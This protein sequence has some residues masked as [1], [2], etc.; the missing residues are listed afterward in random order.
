MTKGGA[1]STNYDHRLITLNY[2]SLML[3]WSKDLL[4]C[5]ARL[6]V[7]MQSSWLHPRVECRDA[8]QW[9][10]SDALIPGKRIRSVDVRL[11]HSQPGLQCEY[12]VLHDCMTAW[13]IQCMTAAGKS[14]EYFLPPTTALTAADMRWW[15]HT[16]AIQPKICAGTTHHSPLTQAQ[17][18]QTNWGPPF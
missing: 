2:L 15:W 7:T 4:Q 1:P 12:C 9:Q 13:L 17:G 3:I 8:L 5:D 16:L 10:W 18:A 6:H 14:G 11:Q